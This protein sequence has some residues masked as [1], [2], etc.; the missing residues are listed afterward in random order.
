MQ[1][2]LSLKPGA[3]LDRGCGGGSILVAA[4]RPNRNLYRG[5]PDITTPRKVP[6]YPERAQTHTHWSFEHKTLQESDEVRDRQSESNCFSCFQS[7]VEVFV[8]VWL[9][10]ALPIQTKCPKHGEHIITEIKRHQ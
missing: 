3:G 1:L 8:S 2:Y 7:A 10:S 9:Q 5:R 4:R 6:G